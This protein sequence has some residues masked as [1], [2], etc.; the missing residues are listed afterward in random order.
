MLASAGM[1]LREGEAVERNLSE[2]RRMY[3]PYA[4]ALSKHMHI[5]IPPWV[6]E[7]RRADDWQTSAW[8]RGKGFQIEGSPDASEDEHF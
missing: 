3:E 6:T 1:T 7:S 8:G 2:L 5:V 4:Y